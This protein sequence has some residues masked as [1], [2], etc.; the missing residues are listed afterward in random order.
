MLNVVFLINRTPLSLLKWQTPY[1]RLY[2]KFADYSMLRSFRCLC[3]APTLSSH[4]SKFDPQAIS[5]FFIGYPIAMKAYRLYDIKHTRFFISRDVVSHEHIFPFA[6]FVDQVD[7]K[8]PFDDVVLPKSFDFVGIPSTSNDNNVQPLNVANDNETIYS[9]NENIQFGSSRPSINVASNDIGLLIFL[10][11]KCQN[12]FS[13]FKTSI[14]LGRLPL[15]HVI[16]S[17][18]YGP[19]WYFYKISFTELYIVSSL[20]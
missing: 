11:T 19:P 5:G 20:V 4:R 7:L 13:S 9:N 17:R 16:L 6:S 8:M 10:T 2:G 1:A 18:H 3:F 12:V 14:L 15:E